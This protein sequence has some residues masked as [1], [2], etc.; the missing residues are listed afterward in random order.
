MS[1]CEQDAR[2]R[3]YHRVH[4]VA[5]GIHLMVVMGSNPTVTA[6]SEAVLPLINKR[7]HGLSLCLEPTRWQ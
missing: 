6:D 4:Y 3:W 7:K 1:H 5:P 2:K